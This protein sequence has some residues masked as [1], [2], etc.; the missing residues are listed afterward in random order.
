MINEI[1]W[2][3]SSSQG[4]YLEN[5]NIDCEDVPVVVLN[6]AGCRI[7]KTTTISRHRHD[8]SRCS[9]GAIAVDGGTNYIKRTGDFSNII[10]LS[11]VVAPKINKHI[12]M[13]I[14]FLSK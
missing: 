4:I 10:D 2:N 3:G 1:D 12:K 9:C 13:V 6:A 11:V 5:K 8:F 7:C 14:S